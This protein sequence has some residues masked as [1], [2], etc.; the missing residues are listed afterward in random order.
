MLEVSHFIEYEDH[1]PARINHLP[2][3]DVNKQYTY[4][5]LQPRIHAREQQRFKRAWL[6]CADIIAKSKKDFNKNTL[7][8][9]VTRLPNGNQYLWALSLLD[10]AGKP[11]H[12]AIKKFTVLPGQAYALDT[13]DLHSD[14]LQCEIDSQGRLAINQLQAETN[15]CLKTN[16][17]IVMQHGQCLKSLSVESSATV[18]F[19]GNFVVKSEVVINGD[20]VLEHGAK[21]HAG[22]NIALLTQKLCDIDRGFI[23]SDKVLKIYAPDNFVFDLTKLQAAKMI[24]ITLMHASEMQFIND[25]GFNLTYAV[26]SDAEV[27]YN[28]AASLTASKS[29]TIIAPKVLVAMGCKD[30]HSIDLVSSSTVYM[31]VL[32]ILLNK[33]FMHANVLG[34]RCKHLSVGEVYAELDNDGLRKISGSVLSAG[35][36]FLVAGLDAMHMHGGDLV[37][38]GNSAPYIDAKRI[39]L[40]DGKF[41]IKATN[42]HLCFATNSIILDMLKD[43][44]ATA[45]KAT[46][47]NISYALLRSIKAR[48]KPSYFNANNCDLI[49]PHDATIVNRSGSFKVK[50]HTLNLTAVSFEALDEYS[51]V[52]HG[53]QTVKTSTRRCL[54]VKTGNHYITVATQTPLANENANVVPYTAVTL[55]TGEGALAID[56]NQASSV[57]DGNLLAYGMN[58]DV[59][60]SM[61]AGKQ[62]ATFDARGTVAPVVQLSNSHYSV[63]LMYTLNDVTARYLY[64]SKLPTLVSNLVAP[65]VL[66]LNG[67]QLSFVAEPDIQFEL[68]PEQE[69]ESIARLYLSKYRQMNLMG[70]SLSDE[71]LRNWLHKNTAAFYAESNKTD[72]RLHAYELQNVA[73][74][75][76]YY[77]PQLITLPDGSLRRVLRLEPHLPEFMLEP[78]LLTNMGAVIAKS[79]KIKGACTVTGL[80]KLEGELTLEMA[81]LLHAQTLVYTASREVVDREII[82]HKMLETHKRIT[83][84]L[85]QHAATI[86]A[87]KIF[88]QT[89]EFKSQAGEFNIGSDGVAIKANTVELKQVEGVEY[90]TSTSDGYVGSASA[91]KTESL[92]QR[93]GHKTT[94]NTSG[95]VSIEA[96]VG[97]IVDETSVFNCA[98]NP[99]LTAARGELIQYVVNHINDAATQYSQERAKTWVE[100][101]TKKI[102]KTIAE[103]AAAGATLCFAAVS[104]DPLF[105]LAGAALSGIAYAADHQV[106]KND[107]KEL[108]QIAESRQTRVDRAKLQATQEI[109]AAQNKLLDKIALECRNAKAEAF[110]RESIKHPTGTSKDTITQVIAPQLQRIEQRYAAQTATVRADY[111]A[112]SAS[113]EASFIRNS[114]AIRQELQQGT[115]SINR[116]PGPTV[117]AGLQA[118][119]GSTGYSVRPT[120]TSGY[121]GRT[122]TFAGPP[123]Y[124]Y[125]R[126]S[127]PTYNIEQTRFGYTSVRDSYRDELD[128][129]ESERER[130][131][132]VPAQRVREPAV[133]ERQAAPMFEGRRDYVTR[134]A[135]QDTDPQEQANH[136]RFQGTSTWRVL[137]DAVTGDDTAR[138][139]MRNRWPTGAIIY[140]SHDPYIDTKALIYVEQQTLGR[141][142][143]AKNAIVDGYFE[144]DQRIRS[145]VAQELGIT[146]DITSMASA[147][148][149][150]AR[151]ALSLVPETAGEVALDAAIYLGAAPLAATTMWIYHS[152]KGGRAIQR[153]NPAVIKFS[154]SS[155]N[156]WGTITDSMRKSGWKWYA[157]PIDVV[158]MTDGSLITLDNTRLLAA[159]DAGIDVRAIVRNFNDPLPIKFVKTE[160]FATVRNGN[161]SIWGEAVNFRI[162]KQNSQFRNINRNGSRYT[163]YG[164]E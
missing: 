83:E 96:L 113:L 14:F 21:L 37:L 52:Q 23:S 78:R 84:K 117:G 109:S 138:Y 38:H 89:A 41:I 47:A 39:D 45:T 94:F 130:E 159:H 75:I 6:P 69:V 124:N 146:L 59:V 143:E 103:A 161:P 101:Q 12:L 70:L 104:I 13:G 114:A 24:D 164:L 28:L 9:T 160:R 153:L 31:Q 148:P 16:I 80:L 92:A 110:Y 25:Y 97:N 162:N 3:I 140:D 79:A 43:E 50:L 27:N 15:F 108:E 60:G 157:E 62:T 134:Y 7:Q 112:S 54:G 87:S 93:T 17:P 99:E 48:T 35:S 90:H 30:G 105:A 18:L 56:T 26:L 129:D 74:P 135:A 34:L 128:A 44:H 11:K 100:K 136:N 107:K 36:E 10:A 53:S 71:Q 145:R 139:E 142:R 76:L 132:E 152:I 67:N 118:N 106:R 156:D 5:D 82:K 125:D 19:A 68:T 98:G 137:W 20:V 46:A 63:N 73:R 55:V 4:S 147:G 85:V 127:T 149:L 32:A 88:G 126:R 86:E 51:R 154:Q 77:V 122:Q 123:I 102:L 40:L 65:P 131:Y 1:K 58:L 42:R 158:K 57:V 121:G 133:A 66:I 72:G 61:H 33:G 120:Y 115:E 91:A 155:V 22:G 144:R 151:T 81:T 95:T 49:L 150:L 119:L 141:I 2:K 8:G 111:A 163:G 64:K 29:L 116:R